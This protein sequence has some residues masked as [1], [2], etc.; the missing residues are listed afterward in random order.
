M[1]RSKKV[2]KDKTQVPWEL[3]RTPREQVERAGSDQHKLYKSTLGR[4]PPPEPP[5]YPGKW[6][7]NG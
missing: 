2:K 6:S 3:Y 7:A 1:G 4:V 5:K